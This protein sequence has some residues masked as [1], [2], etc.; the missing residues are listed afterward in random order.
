MDQA[1]LVLLAKE[2]APAGSFRRF[3]RDNAAT[4]PEL[5]KF[6]SQLSPSRVHP[7]GAKYM[8]ILKRIGIDAV[9]A[10]LETAYAAWS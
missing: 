10:Q 6:A 3:V 4:Y 8:G 1:K 2:T 5:A 7:S 9:A